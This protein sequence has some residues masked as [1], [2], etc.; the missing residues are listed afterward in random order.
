MENTE[1]VD[2]AFDVVDNDEIAALES[3]DR[4]ALEA[5]AA[6]V[7]LA[8]KNKKLEDAKAAVRAHRITKIKEQIV[9]FGIEHGDLFDPPVATRKTRKSSRPPVEAKYRGPKGEEWSGRGLMPR[10]L[11][12][13]I[14][15]GRT[16]EEFLTD[17]AASR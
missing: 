16:K 7:E 6:A 11:S 3:Y 12:A 1:L 5:K 2:A 14:A 17:P 9:A 15:E 8:E 4:A 13:L 10:W